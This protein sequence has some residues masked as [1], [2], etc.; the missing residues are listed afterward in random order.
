MNFSTQKTAPLAGL[1]EAAIGT[2]CERVTAAC[3]YTCGA[4]DLHIGAIRT[5]SRK[6]EQISEAITNQNTA[7]V[8]RSLASHG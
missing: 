1:A 2:K 5:E 7:R 6:T 3:L 4:A 8:P